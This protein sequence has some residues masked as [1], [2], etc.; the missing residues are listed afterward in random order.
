MPRDGSELAAV[1]KQFWGPLEEFICEKRT[2]KVTFHFQAG[3]MQRIERDMFDRPE[4]YLLRLDTE[5][6]KP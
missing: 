2:G 4:E 5:A 1:P 3:T 6:R